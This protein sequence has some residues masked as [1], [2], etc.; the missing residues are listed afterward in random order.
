MKCNRS[1]VLMNVLFIVNYCK[2]GGFD[3]FHKEKKIK[4]RKIII[5]I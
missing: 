1:M 3:I 4:S 2:F 5:G